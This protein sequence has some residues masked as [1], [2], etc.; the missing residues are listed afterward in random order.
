M[1][2]D[3][4]DFLQEFE[5]Q[6][7]TP[8]QVSNLVQQEQV[9]IDS[10][11]GPPDDTFTIKY[12]DVLA[13][14]KKKKSSTLHQ[15][16][17]DMVK[18]PR[19]SIDMEQSAGEEDYFPDI[20][21]VDHFAY[22]PIVRLVFKI[23]AHVTRRNITMW[24][25]L[26]S[27]LN[28][29]FGN[30]L[31]VTNIIQKRN[32][33]TET[34]YE[35]LVT[36]QL[37]FFALRNVDT[38]A[39]F[40]D[41]Q[42]TLEFVGNVK[43]YAYS[44]LEQN[45]E[46]YTRVQDANSGSKKKKLDS[47]TSTSISFEP[48]VISSAGTSVS[49]SVLKNPFIL[50][51]AS[52]SQSLLLSQVAQLNP[53]SKSLIQNVSQQQQQQQL[54]T[55]VAQQQQ[56]FVDQK[57]QQP[58]STTQPLNFFTPALSES[59]T[60][61]FFAALKNVS[62][63]RRLEFKITRV[64]TKNI[65]ETGAQYLIIS[66][67]RMEFDQNSVEV[68][69]NDAKCYV[70]NS[71]PM[72]TCFITQ[73]T[74]WGNSMI[75]MTARYQ[76]ITLFASLGI[77]SVKRTNI[78]V[79]SQDGVC[80]R[81]IE[82]CTARK[83][84]AMLKMI[85]SY[86]RKFGF[87]EEGTARHNDS[88]YSLKARLL[89]HHSK[90][91]NHEIV[92][93]V[94]R[95]HAL[96]IGVSNYVHTPYENLFSPETN[97]NIMQK[98]LA[99]FGYTCT[100]LLNEQVSM[101]YI[102]DL[103][104]EAV[105]MDQ[106]MVIYFSG[107]FDSKSGVPAL[108]LYSEDSNSEPCTL[109]ASEIEELQKKLKKLTLIFDCPWPMK[110]NENIIHVPSL[111]YPFAFESFF[112]ERLTV[113]SVTF[114]DEYLGSLAHAYAHIDVSQD[115]C[116][117]NIVPNFSVYE[118]FSVHYIVL[119]RDIRYTALEEWKVELVTETHTDSSKYVSTPTV[120][121]QIIFNTLVVI[122]PCQVA[123][124]RSGT[125]NVTL[126]SKSLAFACNTISFTRFAP[127]AS[128]IDPSE[129]FVS[130]WMSRVATKPVEAQRVV[131][132]KIVLSKRDDPL[133]DREIELFAH[134]QS[135]YDSVL[136]KLYRLLS[137][138]R[139]ECTIAF[140]TV[141]FGLM[142]SVLLESKYHFPSFNPS[143]RQ[144]ES[145][146]CLFEL[147]SF[148]IFYCPMTNL[149]HIQNKYLIREYLPIAYRTTIQAQRVTQRLASM[150][151]VIVKWNTEN[152]YQETK[153]NTYHFAVELASLFESIPQ[154][155][156]FFQL[157]AMNEKKVNFSLVLDPKEQKNKI[158]HYDRSFS[159][160]ADLNK[161]ARTLL[162]KEESFA[163]SNPIEWET[164]KRIDHVLAHE[165]KVFNESVFKHPEEH[166]PFSILDIHN[167]VLEKLQDISLGEQLQ[168]TVF[169]EQKFNILSI[170]SNCTRFN[171][172]VLKKVCS[173]A[174]CDYYDLIV[175]TS[176]SAL[177]AFG[178][179]HGVSFD[180]IYHVLN[181]LG[182]SEVEESWF[183]SVCVN[184]VEY[185]Q[186][187]LTLLEQWIKTFGPQKCR[188][189]LV[190]SVS[191]GPA[192]EHVEP[193]I[194]TALVSAQVLFDCICTSRL[195]GEKEKDGCRITS[196]PTHFAILQGLDIRQKK[197]SVTS[198]SCLGALQC[199]EKDYSMLFGERVTLDQL[200]IFSEQVH[201]LCASLPGIEYERIYSSAPFA[202]FCSSIDGKLRSVNY[203]SAHKLC[204][205]EIEALKCELTQNYS[206]PVVDPSVTRLNLCK[207]AKKSLLLQLLL[208]CHME[209]IKNFA[210]LPV[211]DISCTA[212]VTG[213][214][215]FF[216][217]FDLVHCVEFDEEMCICELVSA[218]AEYPKNS[219]L[220][221][222]IRSY[223]SNV[224][225]D[226][227]THESFVRECLLELGCACP[228]LSDTVLRNKEWINE[229][230]SILQGEEPKLVCAPPQLC[231]T[232]QVDEPCILIRTQAFQGHLCIPFAS[233][234]SVVCCDASAVFCFASNTTTD[235]LFSFYTQV[236][237][238]LEVPCSELFRVHSV[239]ELHR[240]ELKVLFDSFLLG[241]V[242]NC[243]LLTRH[244]ILCRFDSND[245]ISAMLDFGYT[246]ETSKRVHCITL[247]FEH[248][249]I[250]DRTYSKDLLSSVA[251]ALM[252]C[253]CVWD[254]AQEQG[255]V[256]RVPQTVQ[257]CVV[258]R[259]KLIENVYYAVLDQLEC[260]NLGL[261]Q[262]RC[263]V[264]SQL[265]LDESLFE[266]EQPRTVQDCWGFKFDSTCTWKL[267]KSQNLVRIIDTDG[268]SKTFSIPPQYKNCE[269]VE[270]KY[271]RIF[272][273]K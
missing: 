148:L 248:R 222:V 270:L 4:L 133:S 195:F 229:Y 249:C 166:V 271:Q 193:V 1:Q 72:D 157:S 150:S 137:S 97:C 49:T 170:D 73:S 145:V 228:S 176:T 182:I 86:R 244:G 94:S 224:D 179:A 152:W 99:Q 135:S 37:A 102:R 151:R 6:S 213:K 7:E 63:D 265:E 114:G 130:R 82:L 141:S 155:A 139:N 147:H 185:K 142:H 181:V 217:A 9:T 168:N 112:K 136:A 39:G 160:R 247:K 36:N 183:S 45:R 57:Q 91:R 27:S 131:V 225:G 204:S 78:I 59:K 238:L 189:A 26:I 220:Q 261:E 239:I 100:T 122:V 110:E 251:N 53:D 28:I 34:R 92:K 156:I 64:D 246:V 250:A 231:T 98:A 257:E 32:R 13:A 76:G 258:T 209:P 24:T 175:G 87:V 33:S 60:P 29:M 41:T 104:E 144:V 69:L 12:V 171:F 192:R 48:P 85:N 14:A 40:I 105:A 173:T 126:G 219:R 162:Q 67:A 83:D 198:L 84:Y 18:H 165:N 134:E 21:F 188:Y 202:F 58:T 23:V 66:Y 46:M 74:R 259:E 108:V 252:P 19:G 186:Y 15:F 153:C 17:L 190:S 234:C 140:H 129:S 103:V 25:R 169:S 199:Y 121:K 172:S 194:H 205:A 107:V 51:S 200:G 191:T 264:P 65:A 230:N 143:E 125:F 116:A 221:N 113:G 260:T 70:C 164:L 262:W 80:V 167:Q 227:N 177:V 101:S 120:I 123:P 20:Q 242:L 50:S 89:E 233:Q 256:I 81:E 43:D 210:C 255:I 5:Q 90:N 132:D 30:V 254:E 203:N 71:G 226:N 52:Q 178:L 201:L 42:L 115:L 22:T 184:G 161:F 236:Y 269:I 245:L 68:Y 127:I 35:Y 206:I 109:F 149:V 111:S 2:H 212:M 95:K 163:V 54:T 61:T 154:E 235:Q 232:V 31:E 243:K 214:H 75:K 119:N 196:N 273:A 207:V 138:E 128:H 268:S 223:N 77:E 174:P 124:T 118:C 211:T 158:P 8:K 253:E 146:V 47:E 62:A 55:Q 208:K 88:M 44:V 266:R 263:S 187:V 272:V 106:E 3:N 38:I 159:D 96:V 237:Q 197:M 117:C 93:R 11:Y 216:Y 215:A 267:Y 79:M 56:Q 241:R 10:M 180:E 240:R 16:I 218:R